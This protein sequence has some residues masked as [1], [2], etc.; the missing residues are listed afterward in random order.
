MNDVVKPKLSS[1]YKARDLKIERDDL[2]S[3]LEILNNV[4]WSKLDQIALTSLF[5]FKSLKYISIPKE[6]VIKSIKGYL[7]KVNNSI[8]ELGINIDE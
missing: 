7:A 6:V 2:R 8:N 1:L 4:N 5:S 3:D